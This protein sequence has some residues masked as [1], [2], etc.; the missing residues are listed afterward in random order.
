MTSQLYT[1][2]HSD[3]PPERFLELLRAH[4]VTAIADVRSRPYSRRH[5]QF[6]REPLKASL[7]EAGIAYVYLGRECGAR[8]DDPACYDHGQVQYERLARTALFQAGLSR[9][10]EGAAVFRLALM[11]AE[12]D[13]LSCHRTILVSRHLVDTGLCVEHI[14]ADGTLESH[15]E[16]LVRLRA[17]LG[18]GEPDLFSTDADLDI[19]AYRRQAER[20]AYTQERP[21]EPGGTPTEVIR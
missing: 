2:G 14:L 12:R 1:I 17:Q 15:A 11:C 8:A 9:I 19:L 5:P 6:N 7:Q 18:L 4:A 21:T 13:P 10:R 16:A 3:H 20:I